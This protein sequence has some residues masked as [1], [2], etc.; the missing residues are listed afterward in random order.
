[1]F[2]IRDDLLIEVVDMDLLLTMRGPQQFDKVLLKVFAEILD[3]F[4]GVLANDEHLADVTFASNV[5]FKSYLVLESVK[6]CRAGLYLPFSSRICRSHAWQ[7]HRNRP[8]PLALILLPMA[9]VEPA[10]ARGILCGRTWLLGICGGVE[11]REEGEVKVSR[12]RGE[13]C[14]DGDDKDPYT[15]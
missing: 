6:A 1:M 2:F 3:M 4:A 15:T 13:R 8:R 14:G 10:S 5:A 7:Y 12:D 9:F 11:S